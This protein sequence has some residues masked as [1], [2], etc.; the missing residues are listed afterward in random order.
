M[1]SVYGLPSYR[2]KSTLLRMQSPMQRLELSQKNTAVSI[3]G[4]ETEPETSV[5]ARIRHWAVYSALV[6]A[7][8]SVTARRPLRMASNSSI[9]VLFT[10]GGLLGIALLMSRMT[11]LAARHEVDNTL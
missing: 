7:R 8:R 2:V 3:E 10:G 4:T 11:I 1:S 9:L 5:L 6:L